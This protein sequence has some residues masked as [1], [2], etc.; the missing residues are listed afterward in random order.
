MEVRYIF[1]VPLQG[2]RGLFAT[3]AWKAG[4]V[5]GEYEGD[6]VL[7]EN[8]ADTSYTVGIDADGWMGYGVDGKHSGNP[9]RFINH[10]GGGVTDRPNCKYDSSRAPRVDVVVIRDV[11]PGEQFTTDY[12]YEF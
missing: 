11:N 6:L 12:G 2:Q 7:F 1:K 4:E 9:T 5:V 3:R 8:V 10:Y